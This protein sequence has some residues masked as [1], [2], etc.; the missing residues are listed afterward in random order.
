[1]FHLTHMYATARAG[2]DDAT[3]IFGSTLPDIAI[4]PGSRLDWRDFKGYPRWFDNIKNPYLRKGM[5]C[6]D[7][8]DYVA[9]GELNMNPV[10]GTGWA[11]NLSK[12]LF[13]KL[14]TAW[15]HSAAEWTLELYVAKIHPEVF[16]LFN[17]TIKSVNLETV[18]EDIAQAMRADKKE[19]YRAVRRFIPFTVLINNLATRPFKILANPEQGREQALEACISAARKVV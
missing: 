4:V 2:S 3:A 7:V 12:R 6:H 8:V 5:I 17:K 14:E 19:I 16:G 13:P 9:E 15:G 1:M 18:S 11:F 10:W